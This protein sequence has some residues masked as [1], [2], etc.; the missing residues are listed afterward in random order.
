M[1]ISKI[2]QVCLLVLSIPSVVFS[3]TKPEITVV[4]PSKVNRNAYLFQI[5][6][7]VENRDDLPDNAKLQHTWVIL[8]DGNVREGNIIVEGGTQ[9]IIPTGIANTITY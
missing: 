3:Q 5:I 6:L 1:K 2:L 7:S 8:E 4:A 9:A